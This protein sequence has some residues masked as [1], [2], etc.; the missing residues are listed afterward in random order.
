MTLIR[1]PSPVRS[2][3][4]YAGRPCATPVRRSSVPRGTLV[5]SLS[6]LGL[7][8]LRAHGH[9]S[10][11]SRGTPGRRR[12]RRVPR[13][14]SAARRTGRRP[15][16]CNAALHSSFTLSRHAFHGEHRDHTH[17]LPWAGAI[18]GF[19]ALNHD[20]Q[21]ACCSTWNT[22]AA[23]GLGPLCVK[24]APVS[25][26]FATYVTHYA[27][28]CRSISAPTGQLPFHVEQRRHS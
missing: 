23:D 10:T 20:F 5:P 26:G 19:P 15:N 1:S 9:Q 16:P 14:K 3:R 11:V 17:V 7:R 18:T 27:H 22:P 4:S 24:L 8:Q 28:T 25:Q 6:S 12:L 13:V 21:P 2:L